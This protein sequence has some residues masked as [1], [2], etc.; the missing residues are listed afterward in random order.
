VTDSLPLCT[1]RLYDLE[2]RVARLGEPSRAWLA[3]GLCGINHDVAQLLTTQE[4]AREF[5]LKTMEVRRI[6]RAMRLPEEGDRVSRAL[7]EYAL[8]LWVG[9]YGKGQYV[10]PMEARRSPEAEIAAQ[11]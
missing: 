4:L 5:S 2:R 1:T 8:R 10:S 9:G 7:F 3:P 11:R 6:V